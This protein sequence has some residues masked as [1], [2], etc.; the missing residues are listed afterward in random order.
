[1]TPSR[2]PVA[3]HGLVPKC[4][5]RSSQSAT[6]LHVRPSSGSWDVL[7]FAEVDLL[8]SARIRKRNEDPDG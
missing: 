1:M 2:V 4:W 6:I 7:R 8:S 3:G 5:G